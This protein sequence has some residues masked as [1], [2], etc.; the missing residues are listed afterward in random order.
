MKQVDKLKGILKHHFDTKK[1]F[2]LKN[3]GSNCYVSSW[4]EPHKLIET[5]Y[6]DNMEN[7][8]ILDYCCGDGVHSIFPA[9]KG[10]EVTGIDFSSHSIE[11]AKERSRNF[12]VENNCTFYAGD[13]EEIELQDKKYD[14]I[15]CNESLLYLD[16]EETFSK[17][18]NL[19]KNEGRLIIMESLGN[20]VLFNIKRKMSIRNYAP[21][22]TKELSKVRIQQ[23]L[24]SS[25]LFFVLDR[26]YYFGL[27]GVIP[28]LLE[29]KLNIKINPKSFVALDKVISKV[30]LFK[31]LFFTG[32]FVFKKL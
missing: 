4:Q 10:A 5:T 7:K 16:L 27:F 29:S 19:L 8:T 3:Y 22:S 15:L 11:R 17:F 20:N 32:V 25:K 13:V 6:L 18:S 26:D 2:D 28:F 23:I 30:Y 21:D 12:N 14:L 1:T 31:K 24:K 9:L